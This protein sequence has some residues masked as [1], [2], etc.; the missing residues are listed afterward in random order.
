MTVSLHSTTFWNIFATNVTKI[1]LFRFVDFLC[2]IIW[3]FSRRFFNFNW[4]LLFN[5]FLMDLL[6]EITWWN[7]LILKG[8]ISSPLIRKVVKS[9][10]FFFFR[11]LIYSTGFV[12]TTLSFI[13]YGLYYIQCTTARQAA[14]TWT[15]NNL[16]VLTQFHFDFVRRGRLQL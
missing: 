3:N 15:G 12:L 1:I 14:R 13:C 10:L 8:I 11:Y 16:R 6:K 4:F 9:F 7:P 2:Y 5:V